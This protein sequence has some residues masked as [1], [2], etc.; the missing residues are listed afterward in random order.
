M[1]V[2]ILPAST[3]DAAEVAAIY[4]H[5]VTQ[6]HVTFET[7]AVAAADLAQ[8]MAD[9]ATLGL[10]WLSARDAHGTL[11]GYAYATQWKKRHAYRFTVEST[12]YVAHDHT[13][14]GV[15]HQLYV[16]LLEAVRAC[17]M[18]SVIGVIALPN[19]AS[20]RLHEQLGFRKVAH[21]A[22]VGY[23]LGRW[24]DVGYWQLMQ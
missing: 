19:A 10:P 17:S 20:I 5:Y 21:F 15:G 9:V 2:S 6:T 11:L 14:K 23:K 12:V 13:G 1:S 3:G 18:H 16:A 24:I 8:R 22:Q 7:E 4:N